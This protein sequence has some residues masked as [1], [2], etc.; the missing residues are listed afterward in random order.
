ML[1]LYL[2]QFVN[3][4]IFPPIRQSHPASPHRHRVLLR[5]QAGCPFKPFGRFAPSSH[6]CASLAVPPFMSHGRLRFS[7]ATCL[8]P[9]GYAV[10]ER[11]DAGVL[12]GVRPLVHRTRRALTLFG[13]R[14]KR[15]SPGQQSLSGASEKRQRPTLPPGG[16]VPSALA[17]LTSLFGMGRGGSPPL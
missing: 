12:E 9:G 2:I 6:R 17:G 13:L 3:I 16:A 11:S 10:S 14:S 5:Q 7:G 15:R 1:H 4:A 8:L